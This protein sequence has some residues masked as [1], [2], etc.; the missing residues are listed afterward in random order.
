MDGMHNG[1]GMGVEYGWMIG[2]LV[3]I[4]VILLAVKLMNKNNNSKSAK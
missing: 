1:W 4:I 3:L 2:F